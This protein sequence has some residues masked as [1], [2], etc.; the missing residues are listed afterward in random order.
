MSW[1]ECTR[2]IAGVGALAIILGVPAG[3]GDARTSTKGEAQSVQPVASEASKGTRLVTLGTVAGPRAQ[4]D[5]AGSANLLQVGGR[6][7]LIDGGPG[8]SH[9]LAAAG[10]QPSQIQ[11]IFITHLHFDHTAG[12]ASLFGF[13]WMKRTGQT[14]DVYGP[15]ATRAFINEAVEYLSIP[16]GIYAA[17]MPPTPPISEM[18]KAHDF[19]ISRPTVVYQDDLVKVTAVENTHYVTIPQDR[20]PLGAKRSYSYR[21]DTPDKTIVFTGDTGPSEAV[22]ELAR[23]ADILVTEVMDM[24][25]TLATLAQTFNTTPDKLKSVADHMLKEHLSPEAVGDLAKRAGVGMVILTHLG[26]PEEPYD[27]R[28]LTQGVRQHYSGPVAIANDGSQI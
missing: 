3:H 7:Y 21:F 2:W 23:G 6:F 9:S 1:F 13:A 25:A 5:R 14:I 15:P 8:V 18:V 11:K 17:E 20:R 4:A 10:V 24:D 22:V 19:D 27:M 16:E 26:V 28:V 12:L